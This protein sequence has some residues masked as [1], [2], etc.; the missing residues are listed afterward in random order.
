MDK[1]DQ[2]YNKKLNEQEVAY[3]ESSWDSF[4]QQLNQLPGSRKRRRPF[5]FIWV[6][7]LCVIAGAGSMYAW[8]ANNNPASEQDILISTEEENTPVNPASNNKDD[9]SINGKNASE[10]L[11]TNETQETTAENSK[12]AI[13]DDGTEPVKTGNK[14]ALVSQNAQQKQK[15]STERSQASQKYT[16]SLEKEAVNPEA[17]TSQALNEHA[18]SE[19]NKSL[20]EAKSSEKSS[21]VAVNTREVKTSENSPQGLPNEPAITSQASVN[22]MAVSDPKIGSQ[23]VDP[24]AVELKSLEQSSVALPQSSLLLNDLSS[25]EPAIVECCPF[26]GWSHHVELG[27]QFF[28]GVNEG[29]RF[30]TGLQAAYHLQYRWAQRWSASA[31][32]GVVQRWGNFG[33]F[34]DSPQDIYTSQKVRRGFL[35]VPTSATYLQVPLMVNFHAGKHV[36]STG[37]RTHLLLGVKGQLD[38]YLLRRNDQQENLSFNSNTVNTGWI[39]ESGFRSIVPEYMLAYSYHLSSHWAVSVSAAW[40]PNGIAF[41]EKT[42]ENQ[43]ILASLVADSGSKQQPFLLEDKW[44]AGISLRYKF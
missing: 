19:N 44:Q 11:A 41:A 32:A 26:K 10:P 40:M 12:A 31:G 13:V 6:L 15:S 9:E 36:I 37:I 23:V 2:W 30:F 21:S 18:N 27:A 33:G 34:Q 17:L 28:P 42:N 7:A 3:S 24:L 25:L 14:N 20:T 4:S 39:N 1:F 22:A 43:D 8:Q 38:E 16:S 35:L 5:I 29:S